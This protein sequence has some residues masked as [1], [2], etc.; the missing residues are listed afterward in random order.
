MM[1]VAVSIVAFFGALLVVD[2][3]G[4]DARWAKVAI[5]AALGLTT[6]LAPRLGK[7]PPGAASSV[8]ERAWDLG[9]SR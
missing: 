4:V 1:W 9:R 2:A 3:A 6:A 8:R 5:A 7:M